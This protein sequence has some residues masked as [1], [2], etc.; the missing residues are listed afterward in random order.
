MDKKKDRH[1]LRFEITVD[2][3]LIKL[4]LTTYDIASNEYT[5]QLVITRISRSEVV[6]GPI[7]PSKTNR[8]FFSRSIISVIITIVF[9]S[10]MEKIIRYNPQYLS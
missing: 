6:L 9:L 4:N 5:T 2:R 3:D 1:Q 10:Y 7:L 8:A